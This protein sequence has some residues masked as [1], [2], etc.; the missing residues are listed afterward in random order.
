MA[1]ARLGEPLHQR[2]G[3]GIEEQHAQVDI[4]TAQ[5]GYLADSSC[6]EGPLRTS[7]LTAT[8]A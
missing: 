1:A 4:A 5:L 2:F 3:L 7:T 8:R 6:N